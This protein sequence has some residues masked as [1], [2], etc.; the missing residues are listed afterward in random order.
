MV[1][2][3][4]FEPATTGPPVRCATG[5]R[6][7]PMSCRPL[8]YT[9]QFRPGGLLTIVTMSTSSGFCKVN[10]EGMAHLFETMD[11][12]AVCICG[13]KFIGLA[14]DDERVSLADLPWDASLRL[15]P[16]IDRHR[17]PYQAE[18]WRADVLLACGAREIQRAHDARVSAGAMFSQTH[19]LTR[20][21]ERLIRAA[22]AAG[23]RRREARTA[24]ARSL[25]ESRARN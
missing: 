9:T 11:Y 10:E 6:Y 21:T 13:R 23:G 5:L 20:Q 7:A 14:A 1:G 15:L 3:T 22:I 24:G 8:S 2:A 18:I 17:V 4:G 25:S 12:G 16:C 19:T